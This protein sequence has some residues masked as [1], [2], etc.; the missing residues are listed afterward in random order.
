MTNCTETDRGEMDRIVVGRGSTH[1]I[2]LEVDK[3]SSVIQWEFVSTQYDIAF[4]VY[5]KIEAD[6]GR[7]NKTELVNSHTRQL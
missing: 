3:T 1:K 5:H 6:N 7:K 2:K 4:S